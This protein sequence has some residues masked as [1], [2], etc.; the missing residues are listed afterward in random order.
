[1]LSQLLLK[2]LPTQLVRILWE[3][4]AEVVIMKSKVIILMMMIQK[5]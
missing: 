5:S 3:E 4:R 1:M 2:T